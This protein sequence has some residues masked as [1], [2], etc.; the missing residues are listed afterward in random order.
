MPVV[1]EE[2]SKTG[3]RAWGIVGVAAAVL[4]TA[5][6]VLFASMPFTRT[7]LHFGSW[8]MYSGILDP[9]S[10]VV[11]QGFT[12]GRHGSLLAFRTGNYEWVAYRL[13]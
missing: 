9:Q 8:H 4:L 12:S 5:P 3:Q 1:S 11:P 10:M 6:V 13:P 7:Q 2:R